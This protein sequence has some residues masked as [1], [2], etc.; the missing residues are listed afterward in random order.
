MTFGKP[1][2]IAFATAVHTFGAVL[3]A[4]SRISGSLSAIADIRLIMPSNIIGKALN[5]ASFIAGNASRTADITCGKSVDKALKSV[6]MPPLSAV[7]AS[8]NADITPCI[9]L[10]RSD[11][12][13][14]TS[15]GMKST[16]F[17]MMLVRRFPTPSPSFSAAPSSPD[18]TAPNNDITS[19]RFGA[20]VSRSFPAASP[21]VTR[22]D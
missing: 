15:F 18:T 8:G 22:S 12:P 13:S 14:C 10:D 7:I 3:R 11:V 6:C 21:T 20:I 17:D 2:L 5:N 4:F 9:T 1:F 19:S 16:T